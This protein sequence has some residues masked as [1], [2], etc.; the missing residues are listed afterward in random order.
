MQAKLYIDKIR[1]L[2]VQLTIIIIFGGGAGTILTS[3]TQH[4]KR[5]TH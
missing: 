2:E 4:D 3:Q 1:T 5:V